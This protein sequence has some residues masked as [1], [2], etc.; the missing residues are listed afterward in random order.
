MMFLLD[1]AFSPELIAVGL[2]VTML[3][4]SYRNNGAGISIARFFGLFVQI[5]WQ[6]QRR[7]H[8]YLFR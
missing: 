3:V 2:G 8:V 4:W 5:L 1:I 7:D 6:G